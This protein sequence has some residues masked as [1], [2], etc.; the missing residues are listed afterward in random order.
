MTMNNLSSPFDLLASRRSGKA[1]DMLAPG[2][3][4]AQLAAMLSAAMRVPDHGK[5][6]PW[7][8]VVVETS[9]RPALATLLVDSYGKEK[10]LAS[11]TEVEAMRNFAL[12]APSLVVLMAKL[13]PQSHIPIWEQELSVGAAAMQL[14]NAGHAMGFVGNWL[15][16]WASY[17]AAVAAALCE[18]G[19]RIAGFFFF[20]TAGKP[21]ED[22]IRPEA[23]TV[24]RRWPG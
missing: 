6:T 8:F 7:R 1:R 18:E 11:K 19:E 2:P 23:E 14:L 15:T 24:V 16:G 20:G 21:L 13:N 4:D 12:Q 10:P 22:R 3:T 17:S 5:L 9:A